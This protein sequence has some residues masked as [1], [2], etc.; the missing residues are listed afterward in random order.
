MCMHMRYVGSRI[1]DILVYSMY[2]NYQGLYMMKLHNLL[3]LST[4]INKDWPT[5][6]GSPIKLNISGKS[7]MIEPIV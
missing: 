2:Y 1:D 5:G 4:N 7:A 3:L 6:R